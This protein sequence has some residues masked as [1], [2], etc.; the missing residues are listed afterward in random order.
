MAAT[1]RRPQINHKACSHAATPKARKACRKAQRVAEATC[2]DLGSFEQRKTWVSPTGKRAVV[3][4]LPNGAAYRLETNVNFTW[5]RWIDLGADRTGASRYFVTTHRTEQ[6]A[7]KASLPSSLYKG[8]PTGV[9]PL[10]V[11]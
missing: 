4:T 2:A 3:A 7:R 10:A 5:A 6:A 8:L 9:L 11:A 1:T